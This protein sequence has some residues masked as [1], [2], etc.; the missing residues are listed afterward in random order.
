M[1]NKKSPLEAYY[2]IE[3]TLLDKQNNKP[4]PIKSSICWGALALLEQTGEIVFDEKVL[5]YGYFMSKIT[6]VK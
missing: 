1:S 6:G 5:I 3:E 2:T 4:I